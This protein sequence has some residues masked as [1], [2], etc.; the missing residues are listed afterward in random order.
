ML[1]PLSARSTR[2]ETYLHQQKQIIH[3]ARAQLRDIENTP[4]NNGKI[5]VIKRIKNATSILYYIN[6]QYNLTIFIPPKSRLSSYFALAKICESGQCKIISFRIERRKS[7]LIYKLY[8][9]IYIYIYIC[10]LCVV[11][12]LNSF[13]NVCHPSSP[14]LH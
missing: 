4:Y 9:Y 8:I 10:V 3:S 13:A 2:D 5:K 14:P 1:F 6:K 12:L 11:H 7:D